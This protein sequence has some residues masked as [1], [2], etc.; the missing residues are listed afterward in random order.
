[1]GLGEGAL[2]GRGTAFALVVTLG[3][4][5]PLGSGSATGYRRRC[6]FATVRPLG[7]LRCT[8]A[9]GRGSRL[10]RIG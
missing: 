9:G 10:L 8:G 7:F 6:S 4:H 5:C 3:S 1:M 2:L